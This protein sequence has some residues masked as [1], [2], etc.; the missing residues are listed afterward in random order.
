MFHNHSRS[1]N[2][3]RVRHLLYFVMRRHLLFLSHVTPFPPDNGCTSR[4][5]NMLKQLRLDFD[6]TLL[7][8]SRRNHQPGAAA[9]E[10]ARRELTALGF[11]TGEPVPVP[12]ELSLA[13][14]SA[15][16]LLGA[17]SGRPYTVFQYRSD[18]FG[19]QLRAALARQP[20]DVVH[21]DAIDLHGWLPQVPGL[22]VTCTH[23]DIESD[24]LR[25]RADTMRSSVLAWHVRHQADLVESLERQLCPEIAL[26]IVCSDADAR[27]LTTI[28][29]GS[30]TLVAPN[31][32][33][34][35]YFVPSSTDV[36]PDRVFFVGPTYTFPNRD[37]VE[38]LLQ[39]IWPR[40]RERRPGATLHVAGG[41]APETLAR[42]AKEPQVTVLGR[43]PDIRPHLAAASCV[44][45]PIR[46]G[47]GTRI[48]ILDAW[49]MSK[50]V[51]STSR[52][53]EG[54]DARDG[55]NL[56]LR[57]DAAA[58]ATAVCDVLADRALRLRLGR[59]GYTTVNKRYSWAAVGESLRE[60]YHAVI[61]RHAARAMRGRVLQPT[62]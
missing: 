39:E 7:A 33:D 57:D 44:V 58:F 36:I 47:G 51:V 1:R 22:P 62:C 28:A 43:V 29:S 4:T 40:V 20:F 19:R 21:L 53:A 10:F 55:E 42:F 49:A 34:T 59:E 3:Q 37:A 52:G 27:R 15:D 14:R 54:L 23:H 35:T 17:I 6:I 11:D 41:G 16:H 9:R 8:F 46:Y 60:S 50:P 61:D 2:R 12:G 45:V 56:I 30:R 32:V 48:K 13:R 38:H 25:Q 24:H 31:G 18:A 5:L 26:N